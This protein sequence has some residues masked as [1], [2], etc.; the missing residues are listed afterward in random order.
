MSQGDQYYFNW[1]STGTLGSIQL[2]QA[3][4]YYVKVETNSSLNLQYSIVSGTLPYGLDLLP[5]G[6]IAGVVSTSSTTLV[7]STTTST[8]IL[9]T[10]TTN[11]TVLFLNSALNSIFNLSTIKVNDFVRA[12]NPGIT[13]NTFIRA[14]GTN[15]FTLSTGT[16]ATI[17][18]GT[19]FIFSRTTG[20]LNTFTFSVAVNQL[21]YSPITTATFRLNVK[22]FKNKTFSELFFQPYMSRE[23]R[24]TWN[25]FINNTKIFDRKIMYRPFDPNFDVQRTM[26]CVLHHDFELFTATQFVS[27]ISQNFYTRRFTLSNPK[28]RYAKSNGEV[29]YEVIYLDIIDYNVIG[30]TSLPKNIFIQ[31]LY[32]YP[33]TFENMR[34][35]L[36]SYGE[37]NPDI[38]PLHLRTLQQNETR[39]DSFIPCVVLCYALPGKGKNILD[40]INNENV[41]FNK[42]DFTVDRLFIKNH[43]TGQISSVNLE[44]KP[45]IS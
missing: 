26:K 10:L 33:S 38:R 40:K 17:S 11:T 23:Q 15:S 42:F 21:G 13:P 37:T 25:N 44:Q 19:Q 30:D 20:T 8:T 29:V 36:E 45:V 22:N 39:V 41:Q 12:S 28:I 7:V 9:A 1:E 14:V 6:L 34:A 3:S 32:Y 43:Y 5:N 4:E 31:P 35:Q 18:T 27:I 24:L 16:T 2:W